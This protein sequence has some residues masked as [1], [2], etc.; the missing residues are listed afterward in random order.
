[1]AAR[2]KENHW[3]KNILRIENLWLLRIVKLGRFESKVEHRAP[4]RMHWPNPNSNDKTNDNENNR[5]RKCTK[6]KLADFLFNWWPFQ[7]C[8][9]FSAHP[10]QYCI[11]LRNRPNQSTDC[12]LRSMDTKVVIGYNISTFTVSLTHITV[13]LSSVCDYKIELGR[14][15]KQNLWVGTYKEWG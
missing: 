9:N 12:P 15:H 1:M 14:L 3:E 11:V 6:F 13:I 10:P 5:R 8:D 7:K 4:T 2:L